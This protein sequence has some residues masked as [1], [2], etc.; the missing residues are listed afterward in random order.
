MKTAIVQN[1]L[2]EVADDGT[3]WRLYKGG[4][5]RL[6]TQ[7]PTSRRGRYLCTTTMVNGTQKSF[8]IHRLVAEGFI[9]NPDNLPEVNHKDGNTKNNNADNL[10]WCTRKQN[11][12]HAIKTGLIDFWRYAKPCTDCGRL[13]NSKTGLCAACQYK[14]EVEAR[15]VGKHAKIL[16][17]TDNIDFDRLTERQL[18]YV[19]MRRQGLTYQQIGD[20]LGVSKQC[21]A[22]SIEQAKE[23]H[24]A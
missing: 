19:L 17:N 21:V 13:S 3:V 11:V 2:F 10:E 22:S 5:K 24:P 7:T 23:A 4:T 8:Y 20:I 12:Q 16:D 18:L 6:A 1:G 9:P 15:H 14:R